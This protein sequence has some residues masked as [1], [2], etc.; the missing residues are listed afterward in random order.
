MIW[1][2]SRDEIPEAA[3]RK[4]EIGVALFCWPCPIFCVFVHFVNGHFVFQEG[5]CVDDE[6][7]SVGAN[8]IGGLGDWVWG[9]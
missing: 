5:G 4:T 1:V 2:H 6:A 8:G 7:A 9:G 3:C